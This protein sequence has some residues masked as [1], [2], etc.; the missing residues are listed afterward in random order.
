VEWTRNSCSGSGSPST[1][2][3][4]AP[5][6]VLGRRVPGDVLQ[7]A[8]DTA[9]QGVHEAV[10]GAAKLAGGWIDALRDSNWPGDDELAFEMEVALGRRP[11]REHQ[12]EHRRRR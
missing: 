3:T 8:G 2:A 5:S 12:D 11:V 1:T 4:G 7:F 9:A 6:A 10:P